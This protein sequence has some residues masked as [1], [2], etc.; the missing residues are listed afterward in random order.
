M[1]VAAGVFG[2]GF[3]SLYPAF[4]AHVVKHVAP[5]RRGAAFGGILSA[6]DVGIGTGSMVLG[7]LIERHGFVAAYGTAAGLSALALPVFV[8]ME[9]RYLAPRAPLP[10]AGEAAAG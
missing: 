10:L 3:G 6:F 8:V 7:G 2:L 9:R 4:A 5:A 1:A